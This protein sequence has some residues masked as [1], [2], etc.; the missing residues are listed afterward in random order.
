VKPT[1]L[2]ISVDA[3][4]DHTVRVRV[5]GELDLATAPELKDIIEDQLGGGQHVILDLSAL[6]FIDSSGLQAILLAL[7]SADATSGTLRISSAIPSQVHR[8]LEIAGVLSSLP[9][10]DD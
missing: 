2:T 5:E 1:P 8:L 7:K 9:L 4:P 10:I 6:E 3:G